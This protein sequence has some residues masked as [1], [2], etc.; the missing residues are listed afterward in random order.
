MNRRESGL[1]GGRMYQE[2]TTPRS[3]IY[4]DS[5]R[6]RMIKLGVINSSST[7]KPNF[8]IET[9]VEDDN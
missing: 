9:N 1:I 8:L 2:T 6:Y 4:Y 5:K 3:Q 7:M